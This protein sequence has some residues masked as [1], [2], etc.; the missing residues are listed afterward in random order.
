MQKCQSNFQTM[1]SQSLPVLNPPI[2]TLRF[3][4]R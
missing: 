2:K 3:Y 4:V 1:A